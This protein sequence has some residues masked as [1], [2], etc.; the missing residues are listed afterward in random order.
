M[1]KIVREY[2]FSQE[3]L[4]QAQALSRALKLTPTT[5]RI[6]YARGIDTEDKARRFLAPS[7]HNFLSPF[8]MSGMREA[9]ALLTRARD[10][11]WRVAVFGDYDADGIGAS[12]LLSRALRI[13]G[14][15]P[16]LYIPERS[17]GYGMNVQAIDRI[18]D[19]FLPDLFVTVDCGISNRKEVEYIKEQG[20]YVIVTDHHELPELLPDCVCV[21]PKIADDYPYDNLCGAG[22]AFKLA[23]ALIGEKANELLDFAA[24]STVADSVPL[25]GENRDVVAEGLRRIEKNPRSSFKA[26]LGKQTGP[27]TA[28]TLA[29]TVAPRVNAAGRMGDARSA[30][31]LFLSEDEGEIQELAAKLNAYNLERQKCCDEL[32][33]QASA[34]IREKGAYGHVIML[35][36]EEWNAGF[37]GIVAARIAEEYARPAL[38]FVRKGDMLKGSARS[39]ESVNIFEALRACSEWIDEFGGHAQAAGINVRAENF[40]SLERAL[41]EYIGS[42]Y[43]REDFIQKIVVSEELDGAI[44]MQLARELNALEPYGVGHRRPLFSIRAEKMTASPV[45]PLSPH[46]SVAGKGMDFMYFGGAKYLRL[47]ESDLKKTI[48]FESNLS[49]FRGKEYLKGFIRTVSYDGMSG[50][51]AEQ[52]ALENAL[53]SFRGARTQTAQTLTTRE[54]DDLIA[55]RRK[56]CA[57]GLCLV[58]S[59][60]RT[61]ECYRSLDGLEADVFEPSDGSLSNTLLLSPAPDC[62]LSGYREIAFLD[63]P[64]CVSV[65]TG[66]ATVYRNGEIAGYERVAALSVERNALLGIFAALRGADSLVGD[67]LS[68][69]AR[70]CDSLGFEEDEF[71]FALTVFE[72]LGLLTRTERGYGVVRGVKTDLKNSVVYAAVSRLKEED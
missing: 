1:K 72:D 15:E 28:Q 32:Y 54:M 65:K 51:E 10:E 52:D 35:V 46:L 8:L 16:Y 31:R 25:L 14:I 12:A 3:Q 39:V 53:I 69:V 40:D 9:V 67:C 26:L 62:D 44:S 45:K 18:F 13:F 42:R 64:A 43:T 71:V 37:V 70:A 5:A 58:A 33:A 68:D 7:E 60:R 57:Y 36:G 61:L 30:L 27:I 4:E 24:L 48:V 6:L 59:T 22:V 56:S 34:Q 41:D 66:K 2:E 17:E 11:E 63:S 23:Q 38:L 49:R 21:N 50:R 19:E 20:A 29:F 47:L 55:E